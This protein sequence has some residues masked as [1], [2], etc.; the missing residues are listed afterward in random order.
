MHTRHSL[1][2]QSMSL[3]LLTT[4]YFIKDKIALITQQSTTTYLLSAYF[5]YERTWISLSMLISLEIQNFVRFCFSFTGNANN[6]VYTFKTGDKSLTVKHINEMQLLCTLCQFWDDE[7]TMWK[8]NEKTIKS[9]HELKFRLKA[10]WRKFFPGIFRHIN[11]V[12][13]PSIDEIRAQ[14]NSVLIVDLLCRMMKVVKWKTH[15]A[16]DDPI[17]RRDFFYVFAN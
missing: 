11:L 5:S 2:W 14:L 12:S 8:S 1:S 9:N 16:C 3:I 17:T 13:S 15:F 7:Y 6:C 10:V 4:N